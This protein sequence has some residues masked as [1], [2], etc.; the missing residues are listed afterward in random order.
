[1]KCC[2]CKESIKGYGNNP[3]PLIYSNTSRCCD[4]CNNIYVIPARL[5]EAP[6]SET[7][8]LDKLDNLAHNLYGKDYDELSGEQIRDI[9]AEY[10]NINKGKFDRY[11]PPSEEEQ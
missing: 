9:R 4:H 1:M 3:S 6:I 2:I 7:R 10:D 8:D 5:K 11:R